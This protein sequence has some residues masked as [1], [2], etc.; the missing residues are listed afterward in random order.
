MQGRNPASLSF[1]TEDSEMMWLVK[2]A[3]LCYKRTEELDRIDSDRCAHAIF[4]DILLSS[5]VHPV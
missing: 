2:A 5:D 1:E 3:D 4:T